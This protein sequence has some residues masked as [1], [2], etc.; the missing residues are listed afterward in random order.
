MIAA[1]ILFSTLFQHENQFYLPLSRSELSNRFPVKYLGTMGDLRPG[2]FEAM[3]DNPSPDKVVIGN[4]TFYK[5]FKAPQDTPCPTK[6]RSDLQEL[7]SGNPP[8]A[9]C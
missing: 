2:Y 5:D 7:A 3:Q 1:L 9:A 8:V 4:L 6:W